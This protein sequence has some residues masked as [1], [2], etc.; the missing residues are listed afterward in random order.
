MITKE[1]P[2]I[3]ANQLS[4]KVIIGLRGLKSLKIEIFP[5]IDTV[6]CAGIEISFIPKAFSDSL[7]SKT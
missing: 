1:L 3:A 2:F 6:K 5:T 7:Y 4:L